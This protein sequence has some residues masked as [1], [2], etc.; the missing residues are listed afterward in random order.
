[1]KQILIFGALYASV[2]VYAQGI[3]GI[4]FKET[5][6][7]DSPTMANW[8]TAD[9]D[10]DSNNWTNIAVT[11]DLEAIGFHGRVQVS[12]S[13]SLSPDNLLISPVFDFP[14]TGNLDLSYTIGSPSGTPVHYAIYILPKGTVFTGNETP[15]FEETLTPEETI[16]TPRNMDISS[17]EG[18]QG[19]Q[20]Y[21]RHY[22]STQFQLVLDDVLVTSDSVNKMKASD[23]NNTSVKIYPNPVANYLNIKSDSAVKSVKVIDNFGNNRNALFQ[24]GKIDLTN[25]QPGNYTI[26]IETENGMI[27]KK[28]IK[29]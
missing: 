3:G 25:F 11:P 29:K 19:V 12:S 6:E 7:L 21:F 15:V 16:A 14:P 2:Q 28:I 17:F 10:G 9:L 4:V 1:M 20:I 8:S 27:S 24:D 26:N 22:N 13:A 23:A 18:Q 5:F